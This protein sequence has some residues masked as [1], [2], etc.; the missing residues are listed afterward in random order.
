ME[1]NGAWE[2]VIVC[3]DFYRQILALLVS[4]RS[5]KEQ[6]HERARRE[7]ES[8]QNYATSIRRRVA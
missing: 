5:K 2:K 8:G 1:Y 7:R 6:K 4:T 3:E